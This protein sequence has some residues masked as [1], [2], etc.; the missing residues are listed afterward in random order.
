MKILIVEDDSFLLELMTKKIAAAGYEVLFAST[1]PDGMKKLEETPSLALLDLLL[2]SGS[3]FDILKAIRGDAQLKD[4]PVIIFSNLSEDKDILE[5]KTLGAT[6]F[7]IK[8]NF[9]LD[10]LVKKIDTLLHR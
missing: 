1:V 6:E 5:A 2:P 7:M 3:G 4:I 8:S 9:N 10:E